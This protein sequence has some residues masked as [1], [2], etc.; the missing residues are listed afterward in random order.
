MA[1]SIPAKMSSSI[2]ARRRTDVWTRRRPSSPMRNRSSVG[3]RYGYRFHPK[4][5]A[6][7]QARRRSP[8]H[9]LTNTD[10][11][12]GRYDTDNDATEGDTLVFP[13]ER[14]TRRTKG[15]V[16]SVDRSCPS[17]TPVQLAPP[18]TEIS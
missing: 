13:L 10:H 14:V 12:D 4:Y 3:D 17:T 1:V 7:P 11:I 8:P 5:P 2:W 15:C 9:G 6:I 16:A 18:S